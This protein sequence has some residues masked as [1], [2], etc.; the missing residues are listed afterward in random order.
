MTA[1]N[2]EYTN[3]GQSTQYIL[4]G[5]FNLASSTSTSINMRINIGTYQSVINDSESKLYI[6]TKKSFSAIE[7]ERYSKTIPSTNWIRGSGSTATVRTYETPVSFSI[8]AA[9]YNATGATLYVVFVSPSGTRYT[10]SCTF[11]ITKN[12]PPTFTLAPMTVSLAC[13]DTAA[14]TFTVTAANIPLGATVTYNWSAPGWT[15]VGSTTNSRT[16][17]PSSGSVLPSTISVTPFINGVAQPTQTCTV[18]RSPFTSTASIS[19]AN[20]ICAVGA[21]AIY[22]INAGVGNTVVWSSSNT[23]I[24]NLSNATNSQVTIAPQTQG[25][26]LLNAEITNH[27]NEKLNISRTI[28][29]VSAS[30]PNTTNT[31]ER[32]GLCNFFFRAIPQANTTQVGT[33][34][35]WEYVNGTGNASILN[36]NTFEDLAQVIACPPFSVNLKLISVNICGSITEQIVSLSLNNDQE[37]INRIAPPTNFY[38]VYPNPSKD[39]VYIEVIDKKNIPN[40]KSAIT[41][42]L[43]DITGQSRR[44]AQIKNNTASIN[45]SGLPRGLYILNLNI[46]G[47]VEGHQVIVE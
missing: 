47:K 34:Y 18:S 2:V 25:E 17:Q 16:F 27:C 20:A 3:N 37:E 33:T 36:F 13:D 9:D 32:D 21:S 4:C 22:T 23:A 26:F 35:S 10:S 45:V 1:S 12:P 11:T 6:Y 14:R 39:V 28:T 7:T 15:Q 24:A 44:K 31:Y 8:N 38:Q 42:E 5:N 29:V 41:G 30:T 46:D 19:G 40:N 43:F